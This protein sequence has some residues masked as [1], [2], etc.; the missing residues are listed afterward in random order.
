MDKVEKELRKNIGR[1]IKLARSK[2]KFTQERLAEKLQLSSRYISQLE[3]GIAF[4]SAK[5]I[6]NLC[7]TLNIDSNFLFQDVIDCSTPYSTKYM[8]DNFVKDYLQL[9][10]Y[11]KTILG[12]IAKD[13]LELQ[14][15]FS[16][17]E[18]NR[19]ASAAIMSDAKKYYN[20]KDVIL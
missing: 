20:R 13:L 17:D 9:N 4:G 12:Y 2:T 7:K 15:K 10:D 16:V 18:I 8:D 11:H 19:K 1:N 6:V 14:K 3:R 5:T